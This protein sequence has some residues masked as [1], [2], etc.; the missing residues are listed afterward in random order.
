MKIQNFIDGVQILRTH[1]IDPDGYMLA[2]EHDIIYVYATDREL[3]P[4]DVKR[5]RALGWFQEGASDD[6]P[7]YDPGEPWAAF[8]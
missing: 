5:L 8:T 1:F 6:E 2:A 7:V 4:D 3:A